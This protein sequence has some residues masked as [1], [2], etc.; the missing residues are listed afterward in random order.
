MT[1]F[2]SGPEIVCSSAAALTGTPNA[3]MLSGSLAYVT[4]F[5]AFWVLQATGPAPDAS[6]VLAAADGRVWVRALSGVQESSQAQTAWFVD[7]VAGSDE[8]TGLTSL[9]A[10]KH[11]AEL[12]RRWGTWSPT[13][14]GATVTITYVSADAGGGNDPG[15]FAPVFLNGAVLVQTAALPATSF[16]GSL[17]AVT[18]KARASNQALNSTF[19]TTT[20]AIAANLLLVNATRGNSRAWAVRNLG[21]GNW[22][23]SQPQAA[24]AGGTSFPANSEVDTWANGD[25]ISGY[26]L[27]NVDQAVIG[28][29]AAGQQPGG[30]GPSH[31]V[32]NLTIF[33]P[34]VN[35]DS[36]IVDPTALVS[37]VECGATRIVCTRPLGLVGGRLQVFNCDLQI[38]STLQSN[39]NQGALITSGVL[40]GRLSHHW[41]DYQ[42]DVVFTSIN[43]TTIIQNAQLS[44]VGQ[45]LDGVTLKLV[46]WTQGVGTVFY[47]SGTLNQVQ[48]AFLYT[49]VAATQFPLSGGLQLAGVATGYSNV[50]TA[51][52]TA[53]HQLALTGA[54]L[55]AAAG[56][57]GFGG[58]AWG[59]GAVFSKSGVQ[60]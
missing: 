44:G 3:S 59:A 45:Y 20:G 53:L 8:N 13:F 2:V 21:A 60:P 29:V 39:P 27:L 28:G 55:D 1:T 46:G 16:T 42:S 6:T 11:K 34:G 32:S 7:P 25:A 51:G 50:T 24:F 10:V 57:A 15:Q 9:T 26:A 14:N 52:S 4:T 5:G 41:A 43:N 31:I 12:A 19:T 30:A 47:G 58:L 23:L 56:A 54:N 37:L 33:D 22:L 18:A 36:C 48:G 40:T 49:G 35:S 38:G 17:L